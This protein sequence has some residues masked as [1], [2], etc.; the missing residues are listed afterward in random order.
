[1]SLVCLRFLRI[2]AVLITTYF[3][4][5]LLLTEFGDRPGLSFR[6][7]RALRVN[8][9]ESGPRESQSKTSYLEDTTPE[10]VL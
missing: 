7:D 2:E 6:L 8:D 1:M 4:Y 5:V 3:I 9:Y 10:A